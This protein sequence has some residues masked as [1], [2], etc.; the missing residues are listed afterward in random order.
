[1]SEAILVELTWI[2]LLGIGSQWVAWK[3]KIPSILLL[4]AVGFTAGPVLGFIDPDAILGDLLMPIVSLSVALIL[5]E[6]GLTLEFRELRAVGRAVWNLVSIGALITWALTTVSAWVFLGWG[7]PL[8]LLFG[9]ILVVTGPTVI[10][11]LLRHLQP[12]KQVASVLK[13]EGIVIDPIGALL[14]LMVFEA[15]HAGGVWKELPM[16][17]FLGFGKTI[18]IGGVLGGLGAWILSHCF[19]RYWVP[20][21]LQNPVSLMACVG[22]FTASNHFQHE[23]GLL[24]VTLMGMLLANQKHATVRHVIEFKENLRVLLISGLFIVLAAR[25]EL[26]SFRQLPVAGC[27]GF[28]AMLLFVV[29]P[30]SVMVASI[31]TS[32][33][34]KERWFLSWMA[35]RGIVAA[36]VAAIFALRLEEQGMAGASEL[37][38]VTFIVIVG[39]VSIYGLT[40]G[41]LA[42][43]LGISNPNPQGILFVGAQRLVRDIAK[44]L[45]EEGVNVLLVDNNRQNI[46]TARMAGLPV[47]YGSIL[48]E[49]TIDELDMVGIGRM[50]AM[51]PNS[52]VNTLASLHFIEVFGREGVFQLPLS[53]EENKPTRGVASGLQGRQL[54]GAE[55][56]HGRLQ[57]LID[58]GAVVKKTNLTNN[59]D[60][61]TFTSQYGQDGVPMFVVSESGKVEI[62]VS[63]SK[64]SPVTSAKIVALVQPVQTDGVRKSE[65]S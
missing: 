62:S 19:S 27:L 10:M 64:F 13:W 43:K 33:T 34:Q 4:L 2:V 26:D 38:P 65:S 7:L 17:A 52:E 9:A 28:L 40:S 36:A 29:R 41:I 49:H 11:P 18:V 50:V 47:H 59:F 14:A 53:P 30:A 51:T 60:Y 35:P 24:T 61:D 39:T 15:I 20:E 6:G 12:N 55:N 1:M 21:Y 54:F 42:R 23:S 37:V 44:A 3:F 16:Q 8:S 57:S 58:S 63:E 56:N 48:S 46:N 25:L 22:L 45:H 32:L 31:G 5:F